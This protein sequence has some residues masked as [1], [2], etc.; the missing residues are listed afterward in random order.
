MV[1]D[2]RSCRNLVDSDFSPRYISHL[3]SFANTVGAVALR[4]EPA[5]FFQ[6]QKRAVV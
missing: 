6:I 1:E 4:L 3:F 5:S 2:Q